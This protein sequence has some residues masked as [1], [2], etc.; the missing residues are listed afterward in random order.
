MKT[1]V[2]KQEELSGLVGL[3]SFF[4]DRVN[5][6][7]SFGAA[8]SEFYC[9]Q[10]ENVKQNDPFQ[11][12]NS[13]DDVGK[14]S[15]QRRLGT[16]RGN[17]EFVKRIETANIFTTQQIVDN[18]QLKLSPKVNQI[19][20]MKPI[21]LDD[22][23][24]LARQIQFERVTM[25]QCCWLNWKKI[26]TILQAEVSDLLPEFEIRPAKIEAGQFDAARTLTT[27]LAELVV[28][29]AG[30]SSQLN[31]GSTQ[32]GLPLIWVVWSSL[33]SAAA[34]SAVVLYKVLELSKRRAEFV[35]AVTQELRTPLTTFRMYSEML[36]RDM[37]PDN[38][39]KSYAE[40]L[41][42]EA[43]RRAYLVDNNI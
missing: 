9:S 37:V 30:S 7:A 27:I 10:I 5:R 6:N 15:R 11:L 42:A 26:K 8:A 16:A 21:W 18:N 2:P 35:S 4:N 13:N 3:N 39:R 38:E 36:A 12:D 24:L 31:S 23:L 28:E 17:R 14:L 40:T 19:G 22:E 34:V 25:V 32:S 29:D 1:E 33:L 41:T 43:D 20:I